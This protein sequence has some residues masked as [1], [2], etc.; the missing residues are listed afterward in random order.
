MKPDQ[1]LLG[2]IMATREAYLRQG[3]NNAGLLATLA[4][5]EAEAGGLIGKQGKAAAKK[6]KEKCEYFL[7]FRLCSLKI[8]HLRWK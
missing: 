3:G 8:I 4:D 7:T 2:E 5:L 1:S 6:L